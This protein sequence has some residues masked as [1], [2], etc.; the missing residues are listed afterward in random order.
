[1]NNAIPQPPYFLGLGNLHLSEEFT[2]LLLICNVVCYTW[3]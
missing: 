1:M 3:L 2:N